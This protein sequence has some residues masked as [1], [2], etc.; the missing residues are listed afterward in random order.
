MNW[1]LD[2]K[3]FIEYQSEFFEAEIEPTE[4]TVNNGAFQE[5]RPSL[6]VEREVDKIPREALF[7]AQPQRKALFNKSRISLEKAKEEPDGKTR[8]L[9]TVPMWLR[10]LII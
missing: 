4:R 6:S 8:S 5:E 10:L 1:A 3:P 9:P 2:H 7:G